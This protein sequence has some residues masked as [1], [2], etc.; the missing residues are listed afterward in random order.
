MRAVAQPLIGNRRGAQG[1]RHQRIACRMGGGH[2]GPRA[3]VRRRDPGPRCHTAKTVLRVILGQHGIA[4]RIPDSAGH[5]KVE[6]GQYH[7]TLRQACNRLHKM[8]RRPARTGGARK[9]HGVRWRGLSPEGHQPFDDKALTGFHIGGGTACLEIMANDA[10]EG[11]NPCPM[12][13]LI[14]DIERLDSLWCHPFAVHFIHQPGKA[15]GKVVDRAARG[16][17]GGIVEKRGDQ[18]HQL[19]PAAQRRHRIGD[20]GQIPKLSEIGQKA[21]ARQ[22]AR[23]ALV[24]QLADAAGHAAGVDDK[25]HA[26]KGFGRLA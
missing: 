14:T 19:Q 10:K 24:E 5:V 6:A 22:E 16:K 12:A 25:L 23:R 15:I 18:L 13:G 3:D 7:R 17:I 1:Q 9:D 20:M 8:L 2:I 11:F 21:D 4:Q 26:G